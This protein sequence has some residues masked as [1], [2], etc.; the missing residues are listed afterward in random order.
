LGDPGL[1]LAG[2]FSRVGRVDRRFLD[3]GSYLLVYERYRRDCGAA[4]NRVVSRVFGAL[5]LGHGIGGM[6][7]LRREAASIL[8]SKESFTICSMCLEHRHSSGLLYGFCMGSEECIALH[9]ELRGFS[10][11]FLPFKPGKLGYECILRDLP[12]V[13]FYKCF[14]RRADPLEELGAPREA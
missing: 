7:Y 12:N 1:K 2:G 5:W 6:H 11:L 10:T 14:A 13:R 8:V 4:L 9:A 3:Y